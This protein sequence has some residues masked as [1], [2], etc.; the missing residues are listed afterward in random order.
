MA[1]AIIAR[2]LGDEYQQLVFWKYALMML[3]GKYEIENIRY[4]DNAVKSYDDVVIEYSK[5]QMF[6]D[7]TISKEYIQVKFHMRDDDVFT[8]DNLLD[9]A[10][11]NAKKYSLL[12]NVVA[13]YRNLG[14][15]F[16]NSLFVIYSMWDVEQ[17]DIL[18]ELVTNVDRSF[19]INKLF[20]GKT[21][22]STMGEIRNKICTTLAINEDELKHILGQICIKS[23]QETLDGLKDYVNQQLEYQGLQVVLGSKHNNP[24]TQLIQELYKAGNISYTK[25]FLEDKLRNEGLYSS[26]REKTLIA[27]RSF[28]KHAEDL[29]KEAD[30]ILKLENYFAGRFL[31]EE[32]QWADTIYPILKTF[33][34]ANCNGD[35]EYYIQLEANSTIAFATGRILDIKAGKKIIPIQRVESGVSVWEKSYEKMEY[36]QVICTDKRIENSGDEVAIVIGLSRNIYNDV[37]EYIEE[38]NL[39]VGRIINIEL[40]TIDSASVI[41]GMHAWSLANEIKNI[42]DK[43]KLKEK[44]SVLHV[45]T[46]CPNALIF[47]LGRYSLSFGKLQLYE[48]DFIKQ[49]TCTYY[50]TMMFPVKEEL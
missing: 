13:A 46:A 1:G 11:I 35:K 22:R 28:I 19:D 48:Y 7:S 20:E 34:D 44:R 25:K 16:K 4:E 27:I 5:P 33:I 10:F 17:N 36:P 9:P 26:K 23:R 45:F 21:D 3:S 41:D 24:Y 47:I 42:I 8:L 49:K 14:D 31:K 6:R 50:P 43:R 30:Y 39:A 12:D 15:E 2:Q 37:E 38:A 32:Y 18:N 40:E 29:D